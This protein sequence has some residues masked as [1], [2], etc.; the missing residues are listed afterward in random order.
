MT[1]EEADMAELLALAPFRRFIFRS[2]QLAGILTP[3]TNG[4]DGRNLDFAEGRRSLGFDILREVDAGQPAS[5]RSPHS[6]LTL[7]AALREGALQQPQSEKKNDRYN[8][9]TD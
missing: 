8:D 9:V 2:I 7:I 1:Q 3:A 5:A 4:T 6:I